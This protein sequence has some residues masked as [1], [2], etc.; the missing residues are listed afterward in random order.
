MH[1][2]VST[3]VI[4]NPKQASWLDENNIKKS[5][6]QTAKCSVISQKEI[7]SKCDNTNQLLLFNWC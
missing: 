3:I 1:L 7:N 2:L 6:F 4:S 5:I